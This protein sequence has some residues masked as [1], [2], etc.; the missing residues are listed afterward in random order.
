MAGDAEE[1]KDVPCGRGRDRAR[2]R[3]QLGRRRGG[4]YCHTYGNYAHNSVDCETPG[5]THNNAATFANMMGGSQ[6]NC[7]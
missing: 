4:Q 2:G 6:N 3:D 1:V 7:E 5:P